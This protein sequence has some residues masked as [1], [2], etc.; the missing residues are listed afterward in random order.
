[1]K[2]KTSVLFV[3]GAV[4]NKGGIARVLSLLSDSLFKTDLFDI[5]IVGYVKTEELGYDW[6]PQIT[7]HHL[8][9]KIRP[10]KYGLFKATVE[11]RKIIRKHDIDIL[12]ACSSIIGPLGVISTLF[13]K[14]K[15][16]YWDHSSFFEST[17]HDFSVRG[18]KFTARHADV[19]IPLTKY[20]AKNYH[21]HSKAK[22][23]VQIY[24]PIDRRLENLEHSYNKNSKKIISV[25]RLT[26][27]KNFE[28]LVDVAKV[29]LEEFKDYSWHIYGSGESEDS[30]KAK[31]VSHD[32]EDRVI[33]KGHATNLYDIYKD[34]CLMVMTS[35]SE[36]FPM[37]LLE[38]MASRL[39]LVSFDII[40]GPNEIIRD[41]VNGFLV[42]PLNADQMAKKIIALLEDG[43][44]REKFSENNAKFIDQFNMKATTDQWIEVFNELSNPA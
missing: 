43:Q 7:Y 25:G 34:Y 6:N 30:I 8:L 31:I 10:M 24:N 17:A 21:E 38:G 32:L 23:I 14:T 1:M 40:T 15:L 28:L 16:I 13:G 26:H 2:K 9:K 5:H 3:L 37:T 36:G 20:D 4:A 33:L 11:L 35:R 12:V 42:E 19:V 39:P 18:K 41:G 27:L 29:V 44:L 22:R